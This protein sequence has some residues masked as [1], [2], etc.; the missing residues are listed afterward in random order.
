MVKWPRNL[1]EGELK[2]MTA[3]A[4]APEKLMANNLLNA[5]SPTHGRMNRSKG[6]SQSMGRGVSQV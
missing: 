3:K 1:D 4:A 6:K 2:Y 5:L